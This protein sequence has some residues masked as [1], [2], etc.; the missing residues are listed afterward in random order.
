MNENLE[1]I[2]EK[3]IEKSLFLKKKKKDDFTK[4]IKMNEN[5]EKQNK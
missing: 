4:R 2:K 3:K 5:F 1:K